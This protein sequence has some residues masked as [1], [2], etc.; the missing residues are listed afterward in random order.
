[1]TQ[2]LPAA[3]PDSTVLTLAAPD[4]LR[5]A[6]T[7][8]GRRTTP[9]TVVYIHGL[10]CD[11]HY[12]TP[13]TARVHERL[14][15]RITQIAYDQRGHGDSGRPHRRD[16]TTLHRLADDLDTVLAQATGSVILVAHSAGALVAGAYATHHR[17]RACALSGLVLFNAGGEFPEFPC[18]PTHFRTLS[19]RIHRLR[20][21]RFDA[22]AAL[23]ATV[24]EHRFR[25]ASHRLGSKAPLATGERRTDPRVSADVLEAYRGFH[26]DTEVAVDLRRV[27]SFVYAGERDRVVPPSQTVRLADKLWADFETIPAAGHSLPRSDPDRAAA[28]ILDALDVVYRS[29]RDDLAAAGA[30]EWIDGAP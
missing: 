21:G 18:L 24:L 11:R 19:R 15:G 6:A 3:S 27:P 4:G 30:D 7:R 10:L 29:S 25:R 22:V 16:H 9:A 28:A 26:L 1:M 2:P 12:W 5:L 20:R 17:A 23:A 8:T 13:V 14:D